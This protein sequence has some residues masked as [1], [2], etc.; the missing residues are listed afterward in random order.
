MK[1]YIN[2][3]NTIFAIALILNLL[4]SIIK[5]DGYKVAFSNLIN[6]RMMTEYFFTN[7]SVGLFFILSA[8]LLLKVTKSNVNRFKIFV[9]SFFIL[10][11][12]NFI[13]FEKLTKVDTMLDNRILK[14]E[15]KTV[16]LFPG[17]EIEFQ[18]FIKD[19]VNVS[20]YQYSTTKD[21]YSV[22]ISRTTNAYYSDAQNLDQF[23]SYFKKKIISL[24]QK[25][26]NENIEIKNGI[27]ICNLEASLNKNLIYYKLIYKNGI[28]LTLSSNQNFENEFFNVIL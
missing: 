3:L 7:I 2:K 8:L 9:Y 22:F 21:Y 13:T 19:K 12:Y 28:F 16:I 26:I 4:S 10:T 18:H 1:K 20:Y 15:N 27:V 6:L 17:D 24:N 5:Y 11:T 23:Y 14:I 25:I